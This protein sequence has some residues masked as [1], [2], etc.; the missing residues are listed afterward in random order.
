MDVPESY[1]IITLWGVIEHFEYPKD[2][3]KDIFRIL[4]KDGIVCLWTGD[5][6]SLMAGL[7]GKRWWY[8]QGQHIQMFTRK[9]IRRLFKSVGFTT[10]FMG[11]Y[12][13]RF[14]SQSLNNSLSRYS[15]VSKI[16]KPILGSKALSNLQFTL[17]LS[18]EMFAIFKKV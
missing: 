9:S 2:E 18:G 16:S 3:V 6:G 10:E 4:K 17:K 11:Y 5:V 7:M 12:P 14:T 15:V 13:Y 8:Y 1:D